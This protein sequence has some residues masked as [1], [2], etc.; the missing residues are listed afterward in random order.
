[1]LG[2]GLKV[3]DNPSAILLDQHEAESTGIAIACVLQG[4]RPLLVEVQALVSTSAYGQA[5][6]SSTGFDAKRLNMLLAVLE[7]HCGIAMA[8]QDVFLNLA[9]GISVSDPALDLA[10]CAALV[11]SFNDYSL[12]KNLCLLGE[13]GLTGELRPVNQVAKRLS[14]SSKLGFNELVFSAFGSKQK[15]EKDTVY[16]RF[17][18]LEAALREII[19]Y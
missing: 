5:Q 3:I 13:V 16:H 9:G 19:P 12:P 2:D 18:S 6:R 10:V 7:K 11:S 17:K 14:E 8:G 4:N 1:M 15:K